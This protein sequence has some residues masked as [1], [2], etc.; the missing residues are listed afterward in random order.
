MPDFTTFDDLMRFW[1]DR[2]WIVDIGHDR[3]YGWCL[4]V[5]TS[6]HHGA[7]EVHVCDVGGLDE[8][9]LHFD[10]LIAEARKQTLAYLAK[11]ESGDA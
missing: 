3:E 4:D 11:V 6:D 10:E 8:D 9:V 5:L 2:R 7:P 1:E